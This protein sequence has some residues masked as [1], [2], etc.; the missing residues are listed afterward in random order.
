MTA[1]LY[2]A[3]ENWLLPA[4]VFTLTFV[5]LSHLFALCDALQPEW[6]VKCAVSSHYVKL[7]WPIYIHL[8]INNLRNIVFAFL[9]GLC[10]WSLRVLLLGCGGNEFGIPRTVQWLISYLWAELWFWNSHFL[11]HQSPSVYHYV[12]AHHHRFRTP[13]AMVG[14]YATLSEMLLINSPLALVPTIVL[15]SDVVTSS[16][17]LALLATHI[18]LNHSAHQLLPRWLDDVS[19]HAMHHLVEQRH[20]GASWVENRAICYGVMKRPIVRSHY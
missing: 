3:L 13:I 14:F 8:L 19:Y 15:G 18:C 1:V 7:T 10:C 17:W 6:Y 2:C 20:F 16:C 11:V 12:H 5:I 9:V 4:S